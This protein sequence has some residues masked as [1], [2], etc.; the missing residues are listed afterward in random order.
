MAKKKGRAKGPKREEGE[1]KKKRGRPKKVEPSIFEG[2]AVKGK[3]QDVEIDRINLRD[4]T[5]MTRLDLEPENL[6][7]LKESIERVGLLS[8]VVL[9][10]S[11]GKYKVAAGFRRL[12]ALKA[13]GAKKVRAL[14]LEDLD[15][16]VVRRICFDEN[17]KR[18]GLTDL[19]MAVNC[20]RLE[21]EGKSHGRI[22]EI[23][24]IPGKKTVQR[25]LRIAR[26]ASEGVK[27]ALH[28]GKINKYLA[29]SLC[30]LSVDE[31]GKWLARAMEQG[32][33]YRTLEAE[34]RK[35]AGSAKQ[36]KI[37][38]EIGTLPDFASIMLK[39]GGGFRLNIAFN[40]KE[41]LREKLTGL[42]ETLK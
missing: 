10:A 35:T 4:H 32:W 24:G 31:Q 41:E 2:V 8:N 11:G 5:F 6:E 7:R 3:G 40:S 25:Y 37:S 36:K 28:K 13:S 12:T 19:E 34:I 16:D 1:V 30:K 27:E 33:D 15:K 26:R 39:K 22:C 42:S 21:A 17:L 38:S 18:E 14:V 20:E 29:F 9:V 23:M